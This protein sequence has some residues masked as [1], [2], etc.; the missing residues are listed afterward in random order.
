MLLNN[1]GTRKKRKKRTT[2]N[3]KKKKKKVRDLTCM[4]KARKK[5]NKLGI[6]IYT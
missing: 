2:Q 6:T 1:G 3:S 5:K 4:V